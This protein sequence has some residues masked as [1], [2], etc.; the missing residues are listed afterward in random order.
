MTIYQKELLRQLPNL[1]CTGQIDDESGMLHIS[2]DGLPLCIAGKKADLYW[3]Q[4]KLVTQEHK[5][6]LINS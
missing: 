2:M 6:S 5:N 3:N 4:D 1:N